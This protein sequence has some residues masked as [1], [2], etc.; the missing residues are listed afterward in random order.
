MFPYTL[1][2]DTYNMK[3]LCLV[4]LLRILTI[5]KG[6]LAKNEKLAKLRILDSI[7]S[8]SLKDPLKL[9]NQAVNLNTN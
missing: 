9:F 6:N 1:N 5:S 2:I 4:K 3:L 8:Y 7:A